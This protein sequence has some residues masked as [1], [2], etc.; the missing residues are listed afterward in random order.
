[1]ARPTVGE[2]ITG[3]LPHVMGK[4]KATT[5]DRL[6]RLALESTL[7]PTLAGM[8]QAT[9]LD[10]RDPTLAGMDQATTLDRRDPT[11]AGM[12][13]ATTPDRMDP[14]LAG[15]AHPTLAVRIRTLAGMH[16]AGESHEMKTR[17]HQRPANVTTSFLQCAAVAATLV[18]GQ[19]DDYFAF[20]VAS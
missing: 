12:D 16:Q 7:H 8:D 2:K 4:V 11:L 15:M 9:T 10:R 18:D 17:Q 1:M 3:A 19:R 20:F 6:P 5:L 14:T 13:Q